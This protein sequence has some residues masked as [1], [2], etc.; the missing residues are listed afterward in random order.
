MQ[1]GRLSLNPFD[2]IQRLKTEKRDRYVSG[3]ELVLAVKVGRELGGAAHIVAMALMT[4][5]LCVRRS[6]EVR[7]MKR[8]QITSKGIEWVG[9]KRQG[10]QS[11][12]RGLIHW[13]P[14]LRRTID[15]ALAI[16]R[17][18]GIESEFVFGNLSGKRYTKGGWKKSLSVLMQACVERAANRPG[19]PMQFQPFSLQDI[20]PMAVTVKLEKNAADVVDAT[21]HRSDRM[22]ALFYDRRRVRKAKPTT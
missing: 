21:L 14:R 13:S 17:Y 2:R 6:V 20:R 15:E 8:S 3:R 4:A 1:L 18:H 12:M 16:E 19:G 10:G 7:G 11:E 9:A 5:Y 22:V